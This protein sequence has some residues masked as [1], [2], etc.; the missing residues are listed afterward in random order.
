[1]VRTWPDCG[2]DSMAAEHSDSTNNKTK[3]LDQRKEMLAHTNLYCVF[4]G[5]GFGA[6]CCAG[7]D[8]CH[9][10]RQDP[11]YILRSGHA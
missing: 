9:L 7:L 4:V 11:N 10:L 8:P 5:A 1:M 2:Q 6:T 3:A